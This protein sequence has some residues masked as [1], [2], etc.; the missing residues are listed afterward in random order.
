[1]P[2]F[3]FL[4][5]KNKSVILS[6]F[7]AETADGLG[8]TKQNSAKKSLIRLTFRYFFRNLSKEIF[9]HN[10]RNS[11]MKE[12]NKNWLVE[13]LIDFEYKKYVLLSYFQYVKNNF[14][15]R[16][17]YPCLSDLIF[18]Y[19]NLLQL[20]EHKKLLYEN[21]PKSLTKADFEKLEL[22]YEDVVNDDKVMKEIEDIISFSIPKFKACLSDGKEIYD[23]IED[24]ISISPVGISPL[25]PDEG[26]VFMYVPN[27]SETKI[28][29]YQITLFENPTEK[30]RG[31]HMQFLESVSKGIGNTYENFKIDLI[32]KYKK[33][34][35]PATYLIES[36][37]I[38]PFEETFLPIAKRLLVKHI[39]SPEGIPLG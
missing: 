20:K 21:F 6:V 29:E 3:A 22:I 15:E 9:Y 1:M 7:L 17:L 38:C 32:R 4:M 34:P 8:I 13:G 28:F 26:Y 12:L 37:I 5:P 19:S 25:Y 30:Y 31:V 33:L 36:K 16:K 24:K 11:A 2:F 27:Q 18:H 14:D 39:Y 23:E 10:V 35:N